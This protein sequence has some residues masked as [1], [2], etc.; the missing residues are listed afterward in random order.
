MTARL[1]SENK[2]IVLL[3]HAVTRGLLPR[4]TPCLWL[5]TMLIC[6]SLTAPSAE[7]KRSEG[8]TSA[9]FSTRADSSA[10]FAEREA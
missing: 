5:S 10:G 2:W 3:F 8:T 7:N 1:R 9:P 4:Q 6:C